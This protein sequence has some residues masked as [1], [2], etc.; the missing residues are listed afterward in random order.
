M[1]SFRYELN[2]YMLL[3][4][5]AVSKELNTETAMLVENSVFLHF[6]IT[7]KQDSY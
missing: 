6:A 2:L 3:I 7:Q 4:R 5:N 1:Y